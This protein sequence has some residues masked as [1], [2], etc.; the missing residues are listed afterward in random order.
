VCGVAF[1]PDSQLLAFSQRN[2]TAFGVPVVSPPRLYLLELATG[3]V[4][5]VFADDQQLAFDPR[6]SADGQWLSYLSP[7]LGGV[8]VYHL[9]NGT[10]RFYPTTTGEAAVWHP[11][12]NELVLS[13]MISGGDYFEIHLMLIDP[14]TETRQDI[15]VV[16]DSGEVIAVEDNSPAFS[17]DGEWLAIRRKELEGPRA[18]LGKQLWVM[19]ADGSE[20]YPLTQEAEVDHGPAVWSP[21]GRYLLYHRFPL[22]GPDVTVSVWVLDVASGQSWEVARPGQRPQWVP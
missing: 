6:W 5:P 22:R 7:G 21:D 15:S 13:E 10:T 8:G 16:A 17:P 12:R 18:T 1:S 11:Q 4:A 3:T 9:Q 14:L 19:R 2:A 20:A